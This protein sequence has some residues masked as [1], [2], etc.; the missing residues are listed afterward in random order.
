MLD[1]ERVFATCVCVFGLYLLSYRG[2]RCLLEN[3]MIKFY[4]NKLMWIMN[5]IWEILVIE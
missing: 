1:C 4:D 5:C 2:S 3:N